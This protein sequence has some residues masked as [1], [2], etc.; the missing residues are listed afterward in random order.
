MHKQRGMTFI[1]LLFVIAGIMFIAVIGVK[2]V[3][4][5]IEF[6]A[7]KNAIAKIGNDPSFA[8]MSPR[9]IKD[10]FDKSASIA[11]IAVIDSDDLI[12]E[13]GIVTADYQVV[14]PLVGNISALLDFKA[15]S[16]SNISPGASPEAATE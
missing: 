8:E 13:K 9:Q 7:V 3:P 15:S 4:A 5:Y 12:I 11:Y 16:G 1:G 10:N 6:S 2:L 14:V